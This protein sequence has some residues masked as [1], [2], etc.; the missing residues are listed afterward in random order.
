MKFLIMN[1]SVA[2][3]STSNKKIGIRKV[4]FFYS[5]ILLCT[6][7]W[8]KPRWEDIKF[9]SEKYSINPTKIDLDQPINFLNIQVTKFLVD[10]TRT[11]VLCNQIWLFGYDLVE[12]N[13]YFSLIIQI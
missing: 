6:F 5:T 8:N 3:F 7:H 1:T 13:I 4:T 9:I 12:W 10:S 11:F 2:I